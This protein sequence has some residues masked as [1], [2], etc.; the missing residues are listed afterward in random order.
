MS[1]ADSKALLIQ[2]YPDTLAKEWK[3]ESKYKNVLE[4]D[5]L[6][7]CHPRIGTVYVADNGWNEIGTDGEQFEFKMASS[8]TV[9]DFYF[10]VVVLPADYAPATAQIW[11]AYKH[12]FDLIPEADDIHWEWLIKKWLPRGLDIDES[13]ESCFEITDLLTKDQIVQKFAA[14]GFSHSA[15]LDAHIHEAIGVPESPANF[16]F[17]VD[18]DFNDHDDLQVY[19]TPKAHFDEHS[20]VEC[21]H[22]SDRVEGIF[23]DGITVDEEM[24]SCFRIAE[25]KDPAQVAQMFMD[26]G[27]LLMPGSN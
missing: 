25:F 26:K 16:Y 7:F 4:Q 20:C 12:S 27:F 8:Y 14:A 19:I 15:K 10:G 9:S 2:R 1:T 24:E 11:I 21:V 13:M 17:Y 6:R 3:R 18:D 23:P 5:I 22:I